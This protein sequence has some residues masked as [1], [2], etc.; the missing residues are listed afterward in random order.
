MVPDPVKRN[1]RPL[2]HCLLPG[3]SMTTSHR[4]GYCCA[5]HSRKHRELDRARREQAGAK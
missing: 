3:C 4:G 2:T 5:E 1:D